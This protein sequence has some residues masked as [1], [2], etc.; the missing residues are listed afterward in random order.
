MVRE[1]IVPY[2][3]IGSIFGEEEVQAFVDTLRTSQTLSCG[4]QRDHFEEEFANFIEV[5][6]AF[7]VTNCTVALEF[8]TYLIGLKPGD[9]V[10]ATPLSY[11]ATVQPLLTLPIKVRFCDIDPNSLSIDPG[12]ISSLITPHTRAI[13]LTHYG[14]L[15]ADMDPIMG[16]AFK[17]D[18]IVVEDCA[19]A[20]GSQYKGRFAGATGHIGCFSFQSMKNMSTL[21]EGGMLTFNNDK[22]AHAIRR[23]RGNE[24]D[25]EFVA[26]SGIKFGHYPIPLRNLN[27]HD[28]N[29]YTHNCVILHH[30]GT[31][32]TMSEPCAAVGRVQLRKLNM[33]NERRRQ[34]AKR[35]NSGLSEIPGIRV[36]IEPP[37]YKHVY[38]LY[39]VFVEPDSELDRE[40]LGAA[41]EDEGI[42][43]HLR[44]F[45]IH[46]LPEWRYH[47]HQYGECPV[48]EKIWFEQLLN[49]PCYP[50]L[51]DD[52]VDY[53]IDAVTKAA[54]RIRR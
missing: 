30:P 6:Y 52:Q 33:F 44:Y 28:K 14:G 31:N 20:H 5:K 17:H 25:A 24:P 11:Q 3:G 22:W 10:I 42:E 32:A 8:A 27:R 40:A 45:P 21:G 18:L 37:S 1:Y 47:G 23:I 16:L 54:K 34:I 46:L 12:Q 38:H 39:T 53:M 51:T 15:M 26:R 35:L 7:A 13:F 41:I 9:E 50:S 43:I 4:P 19:H 36:Q 48:M 49:L 2:T 29:A